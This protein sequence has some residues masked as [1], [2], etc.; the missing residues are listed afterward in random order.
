MINE[1]KIYAIEDNV[2]TGGTFFI[3]TGGINNTEYYYYTTNEERG[4]K[5][6]KVK[7]NG[8][9]IVENDDSITST[10]QFNKVYDPSIYILAKFDYESWYKIT[11]PKGFVKN[12]FNIDRIT[13]NWLLTNN[14]FC[15]IIKM[16]SELYAV[17][18]KLFI[19]FLFIGTLL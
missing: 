10:K 16:W 12:M 7:C 13:E 8:V 14:N 3:S 19:S 2:S 4:K 11:V 6:N 17:R 5:I 18:G 9:Y 15:R 1:Q